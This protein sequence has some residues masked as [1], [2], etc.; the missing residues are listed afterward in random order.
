MILPSYASSLSIA[1]VGDILLHT[2]LQRHGLKSGFASLWKPVSPL[3][4]QADISYAN[5]EGPVVKDSKP[6]SF[7]MFNFPY[8]IIPALKKSGF[9]LVSTANNHSLDRFSKGINKTLAALHNNGVQF[10]GT[11]TIHAPKNPWYTVV[12]KNGISTA[13]LACTQDTN[14]IRDKY[15]QVL[16]CYK[17]KKE[18]IK[19]VKQLKQKYDAVII[20]PHWGI[21]YQSKP[22]RRQRWFAKLL[23]EAGAI[24]IIGSHPHCL[25]P[26]Q[27]YTTKDGRNGLIAY[28]L[29][30]FISNQGSLKNRVSGVLSFQLLKKEGSTRI[31][32]IQFHPTYMLNR[33][34]KM[35]LTLIKNSKSLAYRHAQK[36]IGTTYFAL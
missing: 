20:T 2:P 25:Q 23:L 1:T 33:R 17:D 26:I 19:L 27:R 28:S 3:I 34:G 29:G 31:D 24:A 6:S 36:I 12:E 32:S 21:Q 15:H 22:T 8:G 18:I 4:K 11:R 30:N 10:T 13:W 16:Y 9:D 14:G 7:P 5:L 35:V